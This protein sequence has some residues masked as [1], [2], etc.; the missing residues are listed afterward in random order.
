[1]SLAGFFEHLRQRQIR[2]FLQEGALRYQA[3]KGSLNEEIKQFIK[4]NRSE[5][6]EKLE[7]RAN[8]IP[9]SH[10]QRRMWVLNSFESPD[11]YNVRLPLVYKGA[12][13]YE[14]LKSSLNHVFEKNE[15][16]RTAFFLEVGELWQR[17]QPS[18]SLPF[19]CHDFTELSDAESAAKELITKMLLEPYDLTQAPLWR[20]VSVI[21]GHEK[22]WLG[23]GFHHSIVDGGS[24]GLFFRDLSKNYTQIIK[25]KPLE[26]NDL[27]YSYADYVRDIENYLQSGK[28]KADLNYWIQKLDNHQ[29]L[30]LPIDSNRP[31]IETHKG[32]THFFKLDI[33]LV[34]GLQSICVSHGASMYMILFEL[35][36]LAFYRQTGQL[37]QVIGV[38]ISGRDSLE[39]K[40]LY[41]LLLNTLPVRVAFEE[42][43]TFS[44]VLSSVK[45]TLLEAY[46]HQHYPFDALINALD[47]ERDTSRNP[48]FDVILVMQNASKIDLTLGDIEF[49][50][51]FSDSGSIKGDL[52]IDIEESQ[53]ECVVA[54]NYNADL[55]SAEHILVLEHDFRQ[56]AQAFID[57]P[58]QKISTISTVE[59]DLALD[60]SVLQES[61]THVLESLKRTS[62]LSPDKIALE[63][64][65]AKIA[66][67]DIL[68]RIGAWQA[69]FT[70][71]GVS[72]GTRVGIAQH[73]SVELPLCILGLWACGG[74][75]V[76]IDSEF[77]DQRIRYVLQNADVTH[78]VI[79]KEEQSRFSSLVSGLATV[80]SP[81]ESSENRGDFT[82]LDLEAPEL[83]SIAYIFHTSGSTGRPKG[84]PISH[85]ALEVFVSAMLEK[86]I[87][88]GQTRLLAT[89]TISFD[90]SLLEL[91]LPLLAGGTVVVSPTAGIVDG[92]EL[93]RLIRFFDINTMQATPSSWRLLMEISDLLPPS[94]TILSGGEALPEDLAIKL[95]RHGAQLWNLYGPTE[96]TI[97]ASAT[98]YHN[99]LETLHAIVDIGRPLPGYRFA[100]WDE[101]RGFLSKGVEGELLIG[102]QAISVGYLNRADLN[103]EKFI[104]LDHPK[105]GQTQRWYRTGD[106]VRMQFDQRFYFC[107]RLDGQIKFRGFR[108][109]TAEI[110]G[111]LLQIDAISDAAVVLQHPFSSEANLVAF[112][113]AFAER[114]TENE[115]FEALAQRLPN[116]MM[117]SQLVFLED[118]PRTLNGKTDKQALANRALNKNPSE[119]T[120]IQA[121]LT[122][123]ERQIATIWSDVLAQDIRDRNAHFFRR[124]GHS[125]KAMQTI[126]LMSEEFGVPVPL[127]ALFNKPILEDFGVW[128]DEQVIKG[129]QEE[130]IHAQAKQEAV[131]TD[132]ERALLDL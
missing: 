89:S 60:E 34:R 7:Q 68:P 21:T 124:G 102:G 52:Y 95:T 82:V 39:K 66:Y 103:E 36:V 92:K 70:E 96:A 31:E 108:I 77:P 79:E 37:D 131:L 50:S 88:Q 49:T 114:P 100:V 8:W 65:H 71:K 47:L 28:G 117:P 97:W 73:R 17:V 53:G 41:G 67:R 63:D 112:V 120:A 38:P 29:R 19:Q 125:L 129:N 48:L 90:I 22:G 42:H 15:I 3:P 127:I 1:M 12:L 55:Y 54:V 78:L 115:V 94:F 86:K 45:E 14:A 24:L 20:V 56:L 123:T 118:F 111:A 40:N 116:Y 64:G 98:K 81:L 74:V 4:A 5:I 132:E 110:E 130:K 75:Y 126:E 61:S 121:L 26:T 11:A 85:Q 33:Q 10:S 62:S 46:E 72:K 76:P 84:V 44:Q 9:A 128:I 69:Y 58:E 105:N 2:L 13:N 51:W 35:W 93:G 43:S 30:Q 119:S 87:I 18:C 101:Q 57:D 113:K 107:G 83:E 99:S 25:S 104:H 91:V 32:K 59:N 27:K 106:K 6:I 122:K 109:E 23:F 80:I 16:L